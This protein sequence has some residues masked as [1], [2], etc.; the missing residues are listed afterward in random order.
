MLG[1]GSQEWVSVHQLT[2]PLTSK[3]TSENGEQICPQSVLFA[4]WHSRLESFLAASSLAASAAPAPRAA[5]RAKPCTPPLF[6]LRCGLRK[7]RRLCQFFHLLLLRG[8]ISNGLVY[9]A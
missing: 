2:S 3:R 5:Q 7:R 6:P 4:R 9:R 8:A 1:S